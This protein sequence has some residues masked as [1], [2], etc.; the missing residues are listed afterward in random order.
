MIMSMLPITAWAATEP[1][2]SGWAEEKYDELLAQGYQFNSLRNIADSDL[3]RYSF[4]K[5]YED[6]EGQLTLDS[7]YIILPGTNAVNTALPNYNSGNDGQPWASAKP[8]AVYIAAGVTGIGNHAFNGCTTLKTLEIE[9]PSALKRVGEYA[10]NG[11]DQLRYTTSSPLDLSGVTELGQFA[12]N[13]CSSLSAVKLGSGL[14]VI[15]DYAFSSCGLSKIEIPQ[16]VKE[17]GKGAFAS[18]GFSA[19]GELVLPEGLETIGDQAFYRALNFGTSSGFTALTIPSTVTTIGAQAFYNHRQM[20]TVTVNATAPTLQKPGSQAFGHDSSDAYY[21]VKDIT[22]DGPGGLTYTDVK[23]GTQFLTE[24]EATAD[25]FVSGDNC[26]LGDLTPLEFRETISA[27]CTEDGY[28]VYTMTLIGVTTPE[29]THPVVET[30]INIP[31]VGHTYEP[32]ADRPA[33][34]TQSGYHVQICTNE[35]NGLVPEDSCETPEI[36]TPIAEQPSLGHNYQVDQVTNPAIQAENSAPTVVTYTCQ[37]YKEDPAQNRHDGSAKPSYS[38]QIP[39]TTLQADTEDTLA[40]LEETLPTVTGVGNQTLAH[41]EWADDVDTAAELSA[42]L[43]HYPIKLVVSSGT[44]FPAYSKDDFTIA[45]QVGKAPLDFSDIHFVNNI[46]YAGQINESFRVDGAPDGVTQIKVE[47][48]QEGTGTWTT[49]VPPEATGD[50][51]AK[52]QVRVTYSYQGEKH[53]LDLDNPALRP[54]TGYTLTQGAG[55]TAIITGPYEVKALTP[56]DLT[57]TPI[58]RTYTGSEQTTLRVN[59]LPVGAEVTV[60]WEEDGA[61]K[62]ETFTAT[63]TTHD[64]ATI[65]NAGSYEVTI[66]VAHNS[67]SGGSVSKTATAV[68]KQK[69]V[70]TPVANSPKPYTPTVVQT[71]VPD[72]VQPA[73]YTVTGN[74]QTDA[75]SYTA[76][77]ELL[78]KRNYKWS[79]GDEDGDGVAKIPFQILTRQFQKPQIQMGMTSVPYDGTPKEAL[80]SPNTELTYT[81][82][83]DGTLSA[84]WKNYSSYIAYTAT[85][86]KKTDADTYTV[87]VSLPDK[88]NYRWADTAGTEDVTLTWTIVP[89]Q[90]KAPTVNAA[91]AE[92]TGEAYDAAAKITLTGHSENSTG[93][94]E[95]GSAHTYYTSQSGAQPMTGLR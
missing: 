64:V 49:D 43:H 79:S 9:N 1:T 40:D 48:Q 70:S 27:T 25:L 59:G 23:V 42:G 82:D 58:S 66:T 7:V 92:Y 30:H 55:D 69:T 72:S 88:K 81:Y 46:R 14:E 31:R 75:G 87:T 65:T 38:W 89:K 83:A 3:Y 94:L 34:C 74:K 8:S 84:Q 36:L 15:P 18:N 39:A 86:A 57:V 67:F 19:Q 5:N 4:T 51:A 16:G 2:L 52:Y 73:I 91:D 47:Y 53:C 13:G 71:G 41:L 22:D 20:A 45:V 78:D 17:I 24:D 56:D 32:A 33:T 93:V 62:S 80:S 28:H 12:F 77:A 21:V 68:I 76:E 50:D 11:C 61:P 26:Y 37:N 10:F 35:Q 54:P 90:I 63:T 44:T 60:A 95:L 6:D 29:G 85:N